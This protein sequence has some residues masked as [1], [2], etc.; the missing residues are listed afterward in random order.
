M[1]RGDFLVVVGV[2]AL[3]LALSGCS[4]P[5]SPSS[6]VTLRG[7]A[8]GALALGPGSTPS[9]GLHALAGTS[10]SSAITV[11]VQGTSI[12]TTISGNGSFELD[13]LPSGTITLVF[14]RNGVT[15]GTITIS[16][17]P[18]QAEIDLVVHIESTSVVI[19][20]VKVDGNDETDANTAKTCLIAGGVVGSG[21]ELEGSVSSGAGTSF[22]MAVNGQRAGGTVSVDASS[23]RFSCAGVKGSCDASLIR[24]G[25]KVHVSGILSSCS[26]TAAQVKASQVKFQH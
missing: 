8:Q 14:S 15:I 5:T 26:L 3:G 11:T 6:G 18:D 20:N 4:S 17:V 13:G 24:A 9:T 21:I 10:S 12:H 2:A 16:S 1:K 25:A 19:V 23:A 22:E 7:T